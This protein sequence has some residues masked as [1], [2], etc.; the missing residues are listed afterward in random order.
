MKRMLRASGYLSRIIYHVVFSGDI[1]FDGKVY[2]ASGVRLQ[3]TD[4][5][6][7]VLGNGVHLSRGVT[8]IAQGGVVELGADVFIGEWSTIT[9]KKQI[10]V[11]ADTQ[12]AERVTIRDQDHVIH[13]DVSLPIKEAGFVASPVTVGRDVWIGAGAVIVKGV[14]IDDGAVVGANAV[15][16]NQVRSRTVVGGVPAREIGV[17]QR[18]A[19]GSQ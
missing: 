9:A 19:E 16:V 1:K 13:G 18:G 3:A 17:R 10:R 8:V 12:V 15:V 2:L 11:G 4:G 6:V 7:I 5:G 14:G